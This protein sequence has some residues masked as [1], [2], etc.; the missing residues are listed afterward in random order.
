MKIIQFICSAASLFTML[1]HAH[2]QSQPTGAIQMKD[3]IFREYDIRGKVDSELPIN[4]AYDLGRAIAYYLRSQNPSCKTIAIG[5]DGRTHSLALKNELTRAL[6]ESGM[7]TVF[8]GTC[9]TPALYFSLFTGDDIDGGIMITASH[10]GPE[11]NGIKLCLGTR[12]VWGKE[13]QKIKGL[14]KNKKHIL[15]DTIGTASNAPI[16]PS[17]LAWLT[18]H[19]EHLKNI[20]VSCIIDCG[21]GAGGTVMPELV[22]QMGWKNVSLLYEEVDGTFPNHEADP[23]V[24]KNMRDVKKAVTSQSFDFGIGLDG[25]CDRMAPMTQHGELV[26]GDKLLA[27]FAQTVLTEHPGAGIVFDIKSSSGLIELLEQWG[28]QPIMSPSGHSIIKD[29]MTKHG[30]LLG[31]EISCHFFFKDRYFGYDDG[32]YAALRLIELL[33]TTQQPLSELLT[34][35]PKKES[36]QEFRLFCSD[37]KKQDVIQAIKDALSQTNDV[38]ISTIDG[39]R[40]VFPFGWGIVRASNTQ[41][42]LSMRFESDTKE[43]LKKVIE[44]FYALL[45]NHLDAEDL[46]P[47]LSAQGIA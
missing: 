43:G 17:Y 21:N 2:Q 4:Q 25:D 19:F 3:T 38:E 28:A 39:V 10:N 45:A 9:P 41:A 22:K 33:H 5:M 46:K 12:V 26:S 23:T 11:Y 20:P 42:A 24:E 13:L 32:I 47:L 8:V 30:A 35:F 15:S 14:Y 36:S 31:G 37:E 18:N 16:I 27:L 1:T 44:R 6:N 40:A 7:N 29:M 34:I